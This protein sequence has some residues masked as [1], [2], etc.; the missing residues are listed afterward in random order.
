MWSA[1]EGLEVK[2]EKTERGIRATE[3]PALY[4]APWPWRHSSARALGTSAAMRRGC[5]I[6]G[7]GALV[8]VGGAARV[9]GGAGRGCQQLRG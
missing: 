8:G 3:P 6:W 5:T 4:C 9:A 7:A 1:Q 2:V